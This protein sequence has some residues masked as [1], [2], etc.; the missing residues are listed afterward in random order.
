MDPSIRVTLVSRDAAN[1]VVEAEPVANPG[2]LSVSD[3]DLLVYEAATEDEPAM[4]VVKITGTGFTDGLMADIADVSVKSA[5][6]AIL[7]ISNPKAAAVV[8][9]T[10]QSTNQQVKVVVT[11]KSKPSGTP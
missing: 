6:E 1:K 4:V 8:T 11:R 7:T 9:L 10:D 3:V 5:T 2:F